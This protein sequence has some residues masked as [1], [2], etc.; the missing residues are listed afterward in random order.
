[1]EFVFCFDMYVE[2]GLKFLVFLIGKIVEFFI[3]IRNLGGIV[4]V[5]GVGGRER[6]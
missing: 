5:I 4:S 2:G 6:I 1:M 3:M